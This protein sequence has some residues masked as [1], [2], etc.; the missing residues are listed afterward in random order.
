MIVSHL[1][2]Q[3]STP[4]HGEQDG[5]GD[6]SATNFNLIETTLLPRAPVKP[7]IAL[8]A[9]ARSKPSD[10]EKPIWSQGALVRC[11]GTVVW[12]LEA[13]Y[14]RDMVWPVGFRSTRNLRS[15]NHSSRRCVYT[16]EIV[17]IGNR[18]LFRVTAADQPDVSLHDCT[19]LVPHCTALHSA[20]RA[21]L[22]AHGS[23]FR[24]LRFC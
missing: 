22:T 23:K 3:K 15:M 5:E 14:T 21:S 24:P 11:L 10:L 1:A 12:D 2:M 6:P 8:L 17:A 16:S 4:M 9:A 20:A 7:S 13:F 19:R 18:P